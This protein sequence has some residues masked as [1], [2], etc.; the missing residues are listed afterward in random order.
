MVLPDTD[1]AEVQ[2]VGKPFASSTLVETLFRRNVFRLSGDI[3]QDSQLPPQASGT[4]C[5][6]HACASWQT[7]GAK[8]LSHRFF[9][10]I[11]ERAGC[12][13]IRSADI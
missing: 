11:P 2:A 9:T 8:Q 12:R 6:D 7:D 1:G 3:R 10:S 5:R 4:V 13:I